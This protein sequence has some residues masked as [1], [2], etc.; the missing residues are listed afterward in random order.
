MLKNAKNRAFY[1][2]SSPFFRIDYIGRIDWQSD[3]VRRMK[4]GRGDA[5][6]LPS[7]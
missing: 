5:S 1:Q 7:F 4:Q 3:K 2:G 6:Q